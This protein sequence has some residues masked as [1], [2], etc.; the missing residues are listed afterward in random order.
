M[1]KAQEELKN[2][3]ADYSKCHVDL[4]VCTDLLYDFEGHGDL[5]GRFDLVNG[6]FSSC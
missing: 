1:K 3:L 2:D 6:T 4:H 5:Y